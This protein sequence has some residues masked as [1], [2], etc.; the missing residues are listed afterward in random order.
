MKTLQFNLLLKKWK[1]SRRLSHQKPGRLLGKGIL[2]LLAFLSLQSS[3]KAQDRVSPIWWFGASGGANFNFY[4]GS[5]QILNDNVTTSSSFENGFGVAPYVSVFV[6]YRQNKVWGLMFN[7]A[8]DGHRGSF[9]E[10]NAP[11]GAAAT[12]LNAEFDYIAFEPSLRIAPFAGNLYFFI[13]PRFAYNIVNNFT[14]QPESG[15]NNES[16]WSDVYGVRVS[17]QVGVGYEIPLSAPASTTQVNLSP[18]V[19]FLPYFGEQPRSIEDLSLTTVRA[20]IAIKIGCGPKQVATAVVIPPAVIPEVQFSVAPPK[21]VPGQQVVRET[22]PLSNYVF[23]NSG[24]TEIPSRYT[25]LTKDQAVGFNETQLQDCQKNPGTR[26]S[27]QMTMYY[28]VMNI[29]ADRMK[30]HPNATITLIGSSAGKGKEIGTAN[31][32]AVKNYL[33]NVFGIDASRIAIEGRD[34]PIIASE[35]ANSTIDTNLTNVEDNRVDIVSTS[36]YLMMEVKGNSALCLAPIEVLALDGSSANDAPVALS[37]NGASSSLKSWS[38]NVTD[39]AGNTSHYGPFTSDNTTL[40]GSTILN[41][42]KS[43]NYTIVMIAVTNAG[44]TIRKQSTFS[45]MR[46]AVPSQQEQMTSILFEFDKSVTVATFDNF[47]TNTVAPHIL[48]NSTVVISGYTDNVGTA[49]HNQTLSSERAEQ[50]QLIL[51][52]AT[53]KNNVTGVTY[54]T[55]GYGETGVAF[56]NTLPEERFY[57]RTVIIDVI[58]SGTVAQN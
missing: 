18:F 41:G 27:R 6:E 9:T 16:K 8:Y 55:N 31:A 53:S 23:F 38:V 42:N 19:A 45:L 28:N 1:R 29:V 11:A 51:E 39:E 17:A 26:S 12:S 3:L 2:L 58:P 47:L 32:T 10:T 48:S 20:G 36:P 35:Q 5:A 57:N 52:A 43:G 33:V 21:S 56:S 13:G 54:K 49:E 25:I 22:L 24:S 44:D 40:S 4:R 15:P 50:A 14:Y 30:K 46:K 37:I 34:R 7:V